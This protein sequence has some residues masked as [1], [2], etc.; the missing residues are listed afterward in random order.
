MIPDMA[1]ACNRL[2][3]IDAASTSDR[4]AIMPAPGQTAI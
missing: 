3:D 4:R 2:G 1:G